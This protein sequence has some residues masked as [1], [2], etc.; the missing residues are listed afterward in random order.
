MYLALLMVIVENSS[1]GKPSS[2]QTRRGAGQGTWKSL[3]P[4]TSGISGYCAPCTGRVIRTLFALS[5]CLPLW[6]NAAIYQWQ[7]ADG[8]KHF[9]DKSSPKAERVEIKPGY[10]FYQ[11][12]KIYDG[13]TVVLQDGRKIRLLGINT[14][15]VQHRD[16]TA[17]AGGDE[18]KQWLINKLQNAK[19]RLGNG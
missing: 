19:V 5:L 8:S 1:V 9:S 7:D 12:K 14:P 17:D 6:A 18:A 10:G 11:V 16:K 2:E 4:G 13:D 3:K 15:E